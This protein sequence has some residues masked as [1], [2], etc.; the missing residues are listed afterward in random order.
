MKCVQFDAH[1]T[2]GVGGVGKSTSL[3]HIS[4]AWANEKSEQLK[5][6][7]FVFHV[8]LKLIKDN[9]TLEDMILEQH[10]ALK[11]QASSPQEIRK[12][13]EGKKNQK[14][15]LL[16]DG[17]DEYKQGTSKDV[18]NTLSGGFPLSCILLTSRDT[19]EVAEL[20]P[21]MDV[22]AEI[23]GF[24]PERVEEYITKYLGS[25]TKCHELIALATNSKLR[26]E[27]DKGIDY[28]I[29]EIPIMLH[30]ICVLFL[31][32]VSLPKTRTGIVAAIAERC[33]DWEEIRKSGKKTMKEWKAA[34]E[35]ALVKLGEL[36]WEQLQE[37]NK[38]L[39]FLKA[40]IS[41]V[42]LLFLC[43]VIFKLL[44]LIAQTLQDTIFFS[45]S[46]FGESWP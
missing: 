37:G 35:T 45:E 18:Q 34:L 41:L 2:S 26:N 21:F 24:D 3:K 13:L 31:R 44:P 22:E 12:L 28:G 32:K 14:V 39:V 6:F 9:Q 27:T 29:M 20:K 42:V 19:K 23:T 33:P 30:M 5:Q 40:S 4:L 10:A 15:L 43:F 46:D 38:N 36:A 8:A 11:R 1:F 25:D 7:D 16:L 17:Y